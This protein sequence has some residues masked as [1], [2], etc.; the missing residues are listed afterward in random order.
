MEDT[1]KE[2]ITVR[3]FVATEPE[4]IVVNE[5][6]MISSFRI[7]A[8][9]RR[10]DRETNSWQDDHTNWFTVKAF[11]DTARN[12][13]ACV[14]K[15]EPVVVTG[16]LKVSGF[17]RD[18]G[19]RGT[20]VEIEADALGHDIAWGTTKLVRT[21]LPR[22]DREGAPSAGAAPRHEGEDVDTG[23]GELGPAAGTDPWAGSGIGAPGESSDS[24]GTA[25]EEDSQ[26]PRDADAA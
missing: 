3:G 25:D 4:Q 18:D 20:N 5:T 12:V 8:T 14:H 1:M 26:D 7:A 19:T 13:L 10:L 2:R 11:R 24:A 9:A 15:G 16:Q 22:A 21:R 17:Q 6:M 23:T